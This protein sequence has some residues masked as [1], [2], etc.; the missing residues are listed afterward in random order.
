MPRGKKQCESCGHL[1]G[2]RSLHCPNCKKSFAFKPKSKE[3]KSNKVIKSFNW[4]ELKKGDRIKVSGGPY[5]V[6]NGESV[7]M[8]YRGSFVVDSLDNKGIRA[9]GVD[10]YSGFCHIYMGENSKDDSTGM[11]KIRHNIKKLIKKNNV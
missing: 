10:K 9:F 6:S 11:L 4:R 8:G 1:T 5:F 7:S 3:H 2:P